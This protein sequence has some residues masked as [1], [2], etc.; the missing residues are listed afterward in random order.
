MLVL[1]RR[2]DEEIVIKLPNLD[3]KIKIV[4]TVVQID[5]FRVRLGFTAS[6]GDSVVD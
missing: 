1:S 2:I 5:P 4:V 6:L 3:E